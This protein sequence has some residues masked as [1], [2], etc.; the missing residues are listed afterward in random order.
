MSSA[1][2]V[3]KESRPADYPYTIKL[4]DGRMIYVE[5]PGRWVTKDRG[6]E[7][8]FL[9]PAV[10]LLDRMKVLAMSLTSRPVTPGYL[11]S[12]REALGLTQAQMGERAGVDKMTVWR[13]EQGRL[14]PSKGSLAALE[15]LRKAAARQG[16]MIQI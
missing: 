10:R 3:R 1:V 7:T 12:L 15:N 13:W 2:T 6:G 16:V 11:K 9:P 5:I 14:K 8:A 4:P